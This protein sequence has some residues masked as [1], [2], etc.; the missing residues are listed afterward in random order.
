MKLRPRAATRPLACAASIATATL[1]LAFGC[2]TELPLDSRPCPCT[3]GWVCCDGENVCVREGAVCARRDPNGPNGADP[4]SQGDG[5]ADG[6]P[7]EGAPGGD[8]GG[9][10]PDAAHGCDTCDPETSVCDRSANAEVCRCA[11]GFERVGER[12][13]SAFR[14]ERV[15]RTRIA[16]DDAQPDI[17]FGAALAATDNWLAVGAPGDGLGRV[18]GAVYL[19]D[20]TEANGGFVRSARILAAA[21]GPGFGTSVAADDDTLVVSQP[22]FEVSTEAGAV[23]IY[24]RTTGA[25]ALE[26]VLRPPT[27]TVGVVTRF[28]T[29]VA[30]AGDALVVTSST[31]VNAS[32]TDRAA[33]V[34]FYRRDDSGR[35]THRKSIDLRCGPPASVACSGNVAA[36][37]SDRYV[38]VATESDGSESWAAG[39]EPIAS[40]AL[41]FFGNDA[42]FEPLFVVSPPSGRYFVGHPS[43]SGDR[44]AV[45]S[46]AF[47]TN[48][49]TNQRV[50]V[51]RVEPSGAVHEATLE[52]PEISASAQFG[53]R[54]QL[55]GGRLDVLQ[56]TL[57][58]AEPRAVYKYVLD[59]ERDDGSWRRASKHLLPAERATRV[60][61]PQLASFGDMLLVGLGGDST[62]AQT[63][64]T[65]RVYP[66]HSEIPF[67]HFYSASEPFSD[68]ALTLAFEADGVLGACGA[69]N[70]G[71]YRTRWDP[72]SEQ[73][74]Q[75]PVPGL[76]SEWRP[77]FSVTP[78]V[79]V[80]ARGREW[81]VVTR[82]ERGEWTSTG[83]LPTLPNTE[84]TWSG[85]WSF[86]GDATRI[87]AANQA[88]Q[89]FYF[90]ERTPDGWVLRGTY[91]RDGAILTG[92]AALENDLWALLSAAAPPRY[93]AW[94]LRRRQDGTWG[95]TSLRVPDGAKV[96][97]A[98]PGGMPGTVVAALMFERSEGGVLKRSFR[99]SE[100]R[101]GAGWAEGP[102]IFESD[103][104]GTGLV[105]AADGNMLAIGERATERVHLFA[106]DGRYRKLAELDAPAGPQ[107]RFGWRISVRGGV[108]A[109]GAEHESGRFVPRAG[110]TYAYRRK[111]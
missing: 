62:L 12:C 111:P 37:V 42:G 108:V 73:W 81:H 105:L 51:Y 103:D 109:V 102:A 9:A 66:R 11:S 18:A 77:T 56:Y 43:L 55:R 24:R 89:P 10:A 84:G 23:S 88:L 87:V 1:A 106:W 36:A 8:S 20:R 6:G 32:A 16:F 104:D 94:P 59:A 72:H 50:E 68:D 96:W 19:F 99:V 5:G 41:S 78:T 17:A 91:P 27:L 107:T 52:S 54:V 98:V 53:S 45:A 29:R 31:E 92:V 21:R 40:A 110:A 57:N 61:L 22:R 65:V 97:G 75:E 74:I 28:G 48:S 4:S 39:L 13:L 93:Y 33:R 34:D 35:F 47:G 15:E 101:H 26:Q 71:C 2:A 14:P 76:T 60:L 86:Q 7:R 25:V 95:E 46:R 44:M 58:S 70:R 3:T 49:F 67:A 63:A 80:V 64:G 100:F 90:F 79:G 82:D 85:T 30:L 83:T 69:G 38:A